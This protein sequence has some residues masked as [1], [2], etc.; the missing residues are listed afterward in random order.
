MCTLSCGQVH[1]VAPTRSLC[2]E[3]RQSLEARLR[4]IGK[5]IVDGLPEGD[6]LN[7]ILLAYEPE[8][9]VMTPERLSYLIRSDS[10]QVLERFGMFVFDEVHLVGEANRGWTLEEDLT[11]LHYATQNRDHKIVLMSAAIG[12]RN[13]FVEWMNDYVNDPI[14]IHSEWRGPRR[15]HAVWTTEADWSD[16]V[17]EI[18]NRARKYRHLVRCPLYGKL[19]V[20]VSH[21]G[22]THS[23][24]TVE[25]VGDLV[26]KALVTS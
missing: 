21:T 14:H 22:K 11:Y 3:I 16:K 7:E 23:L 20:R 26:L 5:R 2:R 19:D 1:Y 17:Q 6:W 9:E 15:L 4:F 24:R 10:E 25:P 8:V 12:N 13:H 18:N